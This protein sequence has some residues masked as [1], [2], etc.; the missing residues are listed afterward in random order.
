MGLKTLYIFGSATL[1]A[2]V[3]IFWLKNENYD[4]AMK[5]WVSGLQ[6]EHNI[7]C[8]KNDLTTVFVAQI[9]DPLIKNGVIAMPTKLIKLSS[10]QGGMNLI[11]LQVSRMLRVKCIESV[12]KN[13]EKKL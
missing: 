1:I 9:T 5:C 4:F 2:D 12:M 13:Y 11:I 6:N 3:E 8:P 7:A 10:H